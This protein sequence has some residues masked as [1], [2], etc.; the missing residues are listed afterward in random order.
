MNDIYD[1]TCSGT[2]SSTTD[3]GDP[4]PDKTSTSTKKNMGM[5]AA[6]R[7]AWLGVVVASG[8]TVALVMAVM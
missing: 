5:T 3:M 8:G 4:Q 2:D 7:G 6:P 1:R